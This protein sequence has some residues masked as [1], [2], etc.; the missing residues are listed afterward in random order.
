[1]IYLL[2]EKKIDYTTTEIE[3]IVG[4][5]AMLEEYTNAISSVVG[6]IYAVITIHLVN[7]VLEC[8]TWI[9]SSDEELVNPIK[10]LSKE[11]CIA[12]DFDYQGELPEHFY[13]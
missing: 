6:D 2:L 1:M 4:E 13:P 8:K 9:D 7:G 5:Q 10:G 12:V 3:A 11:F